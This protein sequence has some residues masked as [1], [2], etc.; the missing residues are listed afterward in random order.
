M[1]LAWRNA[2]PHVHFTPDASKREHAR[3]CVQRFRLYM[4]PQ[5]L[6][7]VSSDASFEVSV[8]RGR[9]HISAVSLRV[10]PSP[11]SSLGNQAI[12]WWLRHAGQRLFLGEPIT[13]WRQHADDHLCSPLRSWSSV[14]CQQDSICCKDVFELVWEGEIDFWNHINKRCEDDITFVV[15]YCLWETDNAPFTARC[16]ET[17]IQY[18]LS[19]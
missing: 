18:M 19:N 4:R 15:S 17:G 1:N 9:G 10:A 11:V 3:C 5:V 12:S 13:L 8:V 2:H 6:L 14:G 7:M 16:R